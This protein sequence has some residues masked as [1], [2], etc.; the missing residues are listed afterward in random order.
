MNSVLD[1]LGIFIRE[2]RKK[3]HLTQRELAAKLNMS[4]RTIIEIEKCRSSPKFETV[5]LI[6]EE[7]DL[8]LGAIISPNKATPGSVSLS[9]LDFFAGKSEAEVQQYLTLCRQADSFRA[10][11]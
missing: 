8:N 1:T 6:A 10:K 11:K 2:A 7:L 9:V 5:A 3:N 4:V